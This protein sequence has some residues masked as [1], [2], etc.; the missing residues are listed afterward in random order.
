MFKHVLSNGK[1]V[2][3]AR[4]TTVVEVS[5]WD[6]FVRAEAEA[7][8]L[9]ANLQSEWE[10]WISAQPALSPEK[11]YG[12]DLHKA[13]QA[14]IAALDAVP[15]IAFVGEEPLPHGPIQGFVPQREWR[16]HAAYGGWDLR[17]QIPYPA[18]RPAQAD[19]TVIMAE[20]EARAVASK[21]TL[22]GDY[23][24]PGDACGERI[25]VVDL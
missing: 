14:H 18:V 2:V 21:A 10:T 19:D 7:E 13:Y 16:L 9:R 1:V 24:F 3:S 15:H 12:S 23:P 20:R 17:K 25:V 11:Y 4:P 6:A 5:N 22:V 8:A